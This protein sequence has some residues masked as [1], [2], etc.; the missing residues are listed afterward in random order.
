[1]SNLNLNPD[2]SKPTETPTTAADALHD[3]LL[4]LKGLA[5][6]V[7]QHLMTALKS[8]TASIV[9]TVAPHLIRPS[10]FANRHADALR[11]PDFEQLKT[12]IQTAGRNT[13]PIM[14]RNALHDGFGKPRE[15]EA[16]YEIVAGHRRHLACRE[17]GLPVYSIVL[18]DL[19]DTDLVV[20]MHHE[21]HA[22]APLSPFEYGSMLLAWLE[23]GL[24]PSQRRLAEKLGCDH[25]AVSRAVSIAQLPDVVVRAFE[26][27]LAIQ[28]RD[29]ERLKP[30]LE[31][32]RV[33]VM[34]LAEEL[35][36]MSPKLGRPEVLKRLIAAAGTTGV[37]SS[38][39]N[40]KTELRDG[41]AVLG[42]VEWDGDRE[43]R[44]SLKEPMST[45][46]KQ[47]LQGALLHYLQKALPKA[48]KKPRSAAATA[49]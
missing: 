10:V 29:A 17:L 9:V 36:N 2:R 34:A 18:P 37:G 14:V 39:T 8:G 33:K 22:R 40:G 32:A 26:S 28:Y 44:L 1:M 23:K 43:I 20:A 49:R 6:Q 11:G 15:G 48:G 4:P 25:T 19:S 3:S 35:A 46:A 13:Q 41:E 7:Y 12:S 27:P 42:S 30:A 21:N 16:L 31:A 5:P 24:F 45:V 47:E 38:N